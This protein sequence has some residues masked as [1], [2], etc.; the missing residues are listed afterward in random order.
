MV[1]VD[2]TANEVAVPLPCVVVPD[3]GTHIPTQASA[4]N[5]CGRSEAKRC[6]HRQ[7]PDC[8]P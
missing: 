5:V 6:I 3:V 2:V 7:I 1:I 8:G 4:L